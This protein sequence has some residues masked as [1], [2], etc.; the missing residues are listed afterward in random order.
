M[1]PGATFARIV[2]GAF[3]L[4]S[5]LNHFFGPWW[6]EPTGHEPAAVQLLS[7]FAHS[8]LLDVAMTIELVAGALI[9]TGFF[10]PVALTVVMPVSTCA[11]FWALVLEHQVG[12]IALSAIAFALN[13]LLM[14]ACLDHYRGVLR[15]WSPAL[16][17]S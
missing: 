15:R 8:G 6:A 14:F 12:L 1:S 11:L 5:G 13:A 17:E 9:L 2:F 16:G 3:L 10:V 7:A 4:A